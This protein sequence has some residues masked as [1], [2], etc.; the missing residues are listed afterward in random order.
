MTGRTVTITVSGSAQRHYSPNR[1]TVHLGLHADGSDRQAAA[2]Q[3]TAAAV[4]ITD[5][6]TA[7][8]ER[9][10]SPVA[11]W[12]LDQIQ[13]S[14]SRPYHRDGKQRPWVYRSSASAT[15]TFKDFAALGPFIDEVADVEAVSVGHLQWWLTR[16]VEAKKTAHVRDLAVQDALAKAQE[17]TQ[18]LGYSEFHAI[19]IADPGML[20]LSTGGQQYLSAPGGIPAARAMSA[21]PSDEIPMIELTPDRI[22]VSADVEARFEAIRPGREQDS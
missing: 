9:P 10:R 17:Y 3:V 5:A 19:A 2:D 12:S 22:T 21:L 11:R 8:V 18:G 13:H 4:S 15:V 1:C 7:L 16:K 6:V 14:R 20:G